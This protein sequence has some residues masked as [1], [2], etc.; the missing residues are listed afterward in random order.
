MKYYVASDG[1]FLGGWDESP[2]D[3]SIEVPYPPEYA[4]QVWSFTDD[5]YGPSPIRQIGIEDAWRESEL[6]AIAEQLLMLEDYD[7]SSLPGDQVDWRA[8]RVK[9]RAWKTG[10]P[11]FP[12]GSRPARPT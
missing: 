11:G 9:V 8:Y 1:T 10:H 12:F 2:P 3:N 6:P 4:D 7:P 5:A